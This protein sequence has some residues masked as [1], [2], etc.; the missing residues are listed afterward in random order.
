MISLLV[1]RCLAWS[2]NRPQPRTACG[3][4]AGGL[5]CGLNLLLF[6]GKLLAGLASGSLSVLGDALNNLSDCAGSGLTMAGFFWAGQKPDRQ[7][8]FGHGR[9][10]YLAG[11]L[12]AVAILVL[13]LEL[14]RSSLAQ[15]LQPEPA[16]IHLPLWALIILGISLVVKLFLFFFYR[17]LGGKI[18]SLSLQ[19]SALD[20]LSDLLSTGV[21]LCATLL[22][23]YVPLALDAWGGLLVALF[24]LKTGWSA[25]QDTISP[26]LG[27]P[28]DPALA[29]EVSSLV[30]QHPD[31]LGIH[32]LIYHDYGPGRAIMSFH[33]EVPAQGDF[34]ALHQSIDTLE[35]DLQARYQ[36]HTVIHM[37]PVHNDEET[38]ELREQILSLCQALH[39]SLEIH[40][41]RVVAQPLQGSPTAPCKLLFDVVLPFQVGLSPQEIQTSLKQQIQA[42]DPRYDPIIQI[43]HSFV[44][45]E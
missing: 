11:L 9:A 45:E 24:I 38:L 14:G 7:H 16:E 28:M 42:L 8:P 22:S 27:Q 19:A 44:A 31:I 23:P 41:L 43:D 33:A 17:D 40:D 12:V 3:L 15:L 32:D 6:L 5:G 26:L 10:E 35:R 25:L 2:Q 30:N 36:I 13:G 37:D 1:S 34:W 18:Q 29:Q 39:P 21:A 20:S 4:L